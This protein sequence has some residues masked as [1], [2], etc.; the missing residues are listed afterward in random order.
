MGVSLNTQVQI[1]SLETSLQMCFL[2]DSQTT[3]IYPNPLKVPK[4][5]KANPKCNDSNLTSWPKK[6]ELHRTPANSG[7]SQAKEKP[8]HTSQ[9]YFLWKY[10]YENKMGK[11]RGHSCAMNFNRLSVTPSQLPRVHN[12]QTQKLTL[13]PRFLTLKGGVQNTPAFLQKLECSMVASLALS[14]LRYPSPFPF[15]KSL[16]PLPCIS[17]KFTKKIVNIQEYSVTNS[18]VSTT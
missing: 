16:D 5:H 2:Q 8:Y 1:V 12:S 18:Q 17:E 3:W 6:W 4:F 13:P 11:R 7:L 15:L 10:K 14:F 9:P